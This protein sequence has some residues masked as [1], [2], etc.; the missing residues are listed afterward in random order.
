[1]SSAICALD[2]EYVTGGFQN[3]GH[4]ELVGR[5]SAAPCVPT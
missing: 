2:F 3:G 4:D 5:Q 1:M